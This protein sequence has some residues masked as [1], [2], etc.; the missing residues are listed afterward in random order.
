MIIKNLTQGKV[1][2]DKVIIARSFKSRLQGL[3]GKQSLEKNAALVLPNCN[4]IHTFF[5]RF[6]IDVLFLDAQ[7]KAVGKIEALA[8]FR[9]SPVFWSAKTA[10]EFPPQTIK[11]SA[12]QIGDIIRIEP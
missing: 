11:N 10:I 6:P 3:I 1:L 5:M 9:I 12:S 4:G 7:G 8:P 2:A